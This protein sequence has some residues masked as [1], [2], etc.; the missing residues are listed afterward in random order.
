MLHVF[1]LVVSSYDLVYTITSLKDI[2]TRKFIILIILG[3][4]IMLFN[5]VSIMLYT[6]NPSKI[7]QISV[8]TQVN[9]VLQYFCGILLLHP[10]YIGWISPN[11]TYEGYLGGL[12]FTVLLLAWYYDPEIIILICIQ[13]NIGGLLSSLCKRTVGIKDYSTLLGSHG[14]WLDRIDSIVIPIFWLYLRKFIHL[15]Y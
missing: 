13:G 11:K 4:V 14:G 3:V 9:D 8:I 1:M 12:I 6:E 7:I 2:N 5:E 15:R 10:H